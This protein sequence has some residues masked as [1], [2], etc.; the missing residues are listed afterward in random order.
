MICKF[1]KTIGYISILAF[2]NASC[3]P[4]YALDIED[5]AFDIY[6]RILPS[7]P[8]PIADEFTLEAPVPLPEVMTLYVLPTAP[9]QE[10][11]SPP[12]EAAIPEAP[13]ASEPSPVVTQKPPQEIRS[14]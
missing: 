3:A 14:E 12:M 8:I 9:A 10:P 11:F 1:K 6:G 4:L 13:Q 7:S 2:L 5:E